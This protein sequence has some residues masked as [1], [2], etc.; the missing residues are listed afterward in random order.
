MRKLCFGLI[1]ILGVGSFAEGA[2][3]KK[4]NGDVIEGTVQGF[5]ALKG[6]KPLVENGKGTNDATKYSTTYWIVKGEEIVRIDEAGVQR[7]SD[8]VE[9][10]AMGTRDGS[11]PEDLVV[12]DAAFDNNAPMPML[13]PTRDASTWAVIARNGKSKQGNTLS[14]SLIGEYKRGKDSK[15]GEIIPALQV[16]TASGIV[17]I[18][19]AD[20]VA[21]RDVSEKK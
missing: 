14:D 17:K 2:T 20:I 6:K 7:K 16:S 10:F 18:S 21:F 5:V 8:G 15:Q 1:I 3:I 13:F 4:R 19:I 9:A 12:L 11:L